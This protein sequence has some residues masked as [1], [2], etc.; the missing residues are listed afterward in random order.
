MHDLKSDSVIR[1]EELQPDITKDIIDLYDEVLN[2]IDILQRTQMS[3]SALYDKFISLQP[4]LKYIVNAED[5]L[6]NRYADVC[7]YG[8]IKEKRAIN[9]E[10][11]RLITD[12]EKMLVEAGRF[13]ILTSNVA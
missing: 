3:G 7:A 13:L 10:V 1:I 11:Y 4:L 2:V 8:N 12:I 9:M 5:T 6:T